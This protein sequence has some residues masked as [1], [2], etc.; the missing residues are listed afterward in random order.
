MRVRTSF[1]TPQKNFF[2]LEQPPFLIV[3][4]WY[5]DGIPSLHALPPNYKCE[6]QLFFLVIY[7]KIGYNTSA[8]K[9]TPTGPFC[10]VFLVPPPVHA[11][12]AANG[13]PSPAP[14]SHRKEGY[15]E[16]PN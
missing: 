8:E 11:V 7:M 2:I 12:S 14:I 9:S 6:R 4:T 1:S 3:A 5:S 10:T 15:Y 16:A 13:V